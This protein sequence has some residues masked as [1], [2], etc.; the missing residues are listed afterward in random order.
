MERKRRVSRTAA[1]RTQK[2][3]SSG[4]PENCCLQPIMGRITMESI[5]HCGIFDCVSISPMLHWRVCRSSTSRPNP[6]LRFALRLNAATISVKSTASL[7]SR[8]PPLKQ[9]GACN[10]ACR[11]VRCIARCIIISL[12]GCAIRRRGGCAMRMR[13]RLPRIRSLKS[14]E[15]S[16]R[17]TAYAREIV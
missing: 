3:V 4:S 16:A 6:T 8:K 1:Q 13:W 15:E 9:S 17:K 5:L 12:T 11:S 14:A 10:A 7:R 2:Y